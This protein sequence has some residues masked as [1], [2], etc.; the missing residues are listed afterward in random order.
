M[1]GVLVVL[2]AVVICPGVP[3][4]ASDAFAA[5]AHA[6]APPAAA[7]RAPRETWERLTRALGRHDRAA[8]LR[9]LTPSARARHEGD[10]EEWLAAEPFDPARFGKVTS[11]TLSGKQ[12]ATITLSRHKDDGLHAYDVMLMRGDDGR[13]RVDRM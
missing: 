2:A 13:W 7:F 6:D 5:V 11:V 12:F 10:I 1:A 4:A 3:G 9:E 8:A